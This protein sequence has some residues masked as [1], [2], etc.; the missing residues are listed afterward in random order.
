MTIYKE[1]IFGPV[2][3]VVRA[4]SYD[5]ALDLV[6]NHAFGNGTTIYTSDG[7]ASRHFTIILKLEWS[8]LMF[9]F[10]FLWPFIVWRMEAVSIWRLLYAWN[11]RYRFYSKLKTVTSRWLSI[12]QEQ[13]LKCQ[14]IKCTN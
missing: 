7:E 13:N 6:N 11:G 2:V 4:K 10:L 1:E 9:Q 5:E 14:R 8:E 3:S 12:N